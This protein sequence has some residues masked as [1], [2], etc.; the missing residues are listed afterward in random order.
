MSFVLNGTGCILIKKCMR[1][2]QVTK[3]LMDTK[4]AHPE[5]KKRK[6]LCKLY[7]QLIC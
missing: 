4:I 6:V 3:F 2:V 7:T 1:I 5:R